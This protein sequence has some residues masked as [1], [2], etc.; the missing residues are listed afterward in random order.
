MGKEA[1]IDNIF[2]GWASTPK[3]VGKEAAMDN[4]LLAEPQLQNLWV[5]KLSWTIFYWRSLISTIYG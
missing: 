5:K 1:V 2:T 3:F 4:F